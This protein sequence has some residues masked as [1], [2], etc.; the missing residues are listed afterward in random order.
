MKLIFAFRKLLQIECDFF[1]TLKQLTK[2][3]EVSPGEKKSGENMVWWKGLH[4]YS[5]LQ[6]WPLC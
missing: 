1:A 6:I 4:D 3:L 2:K 5:L